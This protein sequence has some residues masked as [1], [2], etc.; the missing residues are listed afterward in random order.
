MQQA[1]Q[2]KRKY[3]PQYEIRKSSRHKLLHRLGSA[4]DAVGNELDR[5]DKL[6][7]S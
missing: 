5:Y 6:K 7:W 3:D 1:G 4:K 2:Y